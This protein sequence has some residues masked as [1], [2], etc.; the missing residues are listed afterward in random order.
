[1]KSAHRYL[2]RVQTMVEVQIVDIRSDTDAVE[3]QFTELQLPKVP[4]FPVLISSFVAAEAVS[5]PVSSTTPCGRPFV[6]P[7]L[8]APSVNTKYSS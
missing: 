1:M 5:Y 7:A 2:I 3:D 8:L 4:A 6:Q